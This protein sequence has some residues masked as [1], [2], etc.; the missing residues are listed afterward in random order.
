MAEHVRALISPVAVAIYAT[1]R[2]RQWTADSKPP[3]L[4]RRTIFC[5]SLCRPAR[6]SRMFSTIGGMIKSSYS[7]V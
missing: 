2:A 6:K 1:R 3:R 7:L 5:I 4:Q